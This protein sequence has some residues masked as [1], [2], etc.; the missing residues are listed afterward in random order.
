MLYVEK[1]KALLIG[2]ICVL[3]LVYTSP[4]L[5]KD[6]GVDESSNIPAWLPHK[7]LS[8]GLDLQG[9][10]HLL[11]EVDI[12]AGI[13]QRAA[14]FEDTVRSALRGSGIRRSSPERLGAAV[15][16]RTLDPADAVRAAN[17]IQDADRSAEVTVGENGSITVGFKA[18]DAAELRTNILSQV[19][20]IIRIRIDEL[21]T[22]EPIIQRQGDNRVVIQVP[23]YDDS[24]KLKNIIGT[25]AQLNFRLVD[26]NADPSSFTPR[27]GFDLLPGKDARSGQL[28]KYVVK[29]SPMVAG[30]LLVDSQPS[31]QD[32]RPVVSFRFNGEGARRF[33]DLT[34]KHIGQPLAIVLD[35]QVISAPTIQ[36]AIG[37]NGIITGQFSVAE[38]QDLALLLRSGAL[39]APIQF[40]QESTVGPS[41]G[42]DSVEAGKLASVIAFVAVAAFMVFSYGL[43]GIFAALAL[44]FN[45]GLI[46]GIL[47]ALQA[48]LTLPGIAGIVLTIGMAVDA[49]VLIFERIR[50]ELASGQSVVS[51]ID[52]G[53]RRA[54]SSIIDSQVTTLIAAVILFAMGSG[55]IRGFSVTLTIGIVT[56][57][58]TA[59][60]VTRLM[61][62]TWLRAGSR[63]KTLPI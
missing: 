17:L 20:E 10:A 38:T 54:L 31:F 23:G 29:T 44:V 46:L 2:L 48:T 33:L 47:S 26:T 45:A 51:A 61:V 16:F 8:L 14:A 22:K 57:L 36:S 50:E 43:F 6:N 32:N 60:W 9:G 63:R 28:P 55:P 49:N 15:R 13:K 12:E 5:W 3:G 1:W 42:R 4:N 34:G 53:Y 56:S 39:P 62:V 7:T 27:P 58:F 52:G 35:N 37:A 11:A 25:T 40:L 19:I 41:L 18:E 21:G 24:A 30:D 59:I